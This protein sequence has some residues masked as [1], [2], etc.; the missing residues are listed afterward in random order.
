[1]ATYYWKGGA[2]ATWNGK[3][4]PQ[5]SSPVICPTT[6]FRAG[7]TYSKWVGHD[8]ND[9]NNWTLVPPLQG[10][11]TYTGYPAA[12]SAP[13]PGSDLVFTKLFNFGDQ[14]ILN[15]NALPI[16]YSTPIGFIRVPGG[17]TAARM[18]SVTIG[19]NTIFDIGIWRG[20]YTA[21]DY[22]DPN[23]CQGIIG[24]EKWGSSQWSNGLGCCAFSFYAKDLYLKTPINAFT[25]QC[26]LY[27][28]KGTDVGVTDDC[29]VHAHSNGSFPN[30]SGVFYHL[31]GYIKKITNDNVVNAAGNIV[32]HGP[33]TVFGL[34]GVHIKDEKAIECNPQSFT[35]FRI[36]PGVSFAHPNAKINLLGKGN[37]VFANTGVNMPNVTINM[38]SY[39]DDSTLNSRIIVNGGFANYDGYLQE[40]GDTH[41]DYNYY[42][43][44]IGCTLGVGQCPPATFGT[45][46][47][48]DYQYRSTQDP[49][50]EVD[51]GKCHIDK[52]KI[53]NGRLNIIGNLGTDKV[54]IN[55]GYLNP[56]RASIASD[57]SCLQINDDRT[58][59]G[60]FVI[61]NDGTDGPNNIPIIVQGNE[62]LKYDVTVPGYSFGEIIFNF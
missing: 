23:S 10:G 5:A 25:G 29:T 2:T 41:V 14:S 19:E 9:K 27:L 58:V 24:V 16:G 53:E 55:G 26:F 6:G 43:Y 22:G 8:V 21:L 13:P 40:Q 39:N 20:G 37:M 42:D 57:S 35:R 28:I 51:R 54:T 62:N 46:N 61:R 52:L 18:N 38:L 45:I 4:S 48:S 31:S 11:Y 17:S 7:H 50:V 33:D 30:S 56:V 36:N 3:I 49:F 12:P 34:T 15:V 60:G 32:L 59:N 47:L 1:M 44:I